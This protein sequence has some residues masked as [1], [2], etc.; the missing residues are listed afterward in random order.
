MEAKARK[1][2]V[3]LR[4]NNRCIA[5][6]TD[7]IDQEK[8]NM[9]DAE[10]ARDYEKSCEE[11]DLA[12]QQFE[13]EKDRFYN[14]EVKNYDKLIG[15][16]ENEEIKVIYVSPFDTFIKELQAICRCKGTK[17][18]MVNPVSMPSGH[19]FDRHIAESILKGQFKKLNQSTAPNVL[20]HDKFTRSLIM[21]LNKFKD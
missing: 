10:Y 6:Q 4:K 18:T 19:V 9:D 14:E 3:Q 17:K 2:R 20:R 1:L 12:Y 5:R 7:I 13:D 16:A 11:M 21:L 8:L 15:E